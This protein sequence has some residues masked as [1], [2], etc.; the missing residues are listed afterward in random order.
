MRPGRLNLMTAGRGISHSEETPTVNSGVLQGV[1]LWVALPDAARARP[2]AFAHHADL[3]VFTAGG[4]RATVIMSELGDAVSPAT[5][6]SPLT[7]AEITAAAGAEGVVP[8][9]ADFEYAV[10]TLDGAAMIDGQELKPGPLL[11]VGEGRTSLRIAA[12]PATRVLLLGG[13]PSTESLVMW[14][15]FVARTHEEV[16]EARAAWESGSLFGEV[17]GYEG[18]PLPAPPMPITRLVPRGRIR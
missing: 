7:S 12:G 17:H 1:Q 14:W 15:N 6:F 4:L 10:L 13:E 9:R 8:L 11:Y 18:P 3:P 2:P 5:T 16:L